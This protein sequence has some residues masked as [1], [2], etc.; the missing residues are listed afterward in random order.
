M[1]LLK[2]R[3]LTVWLG[4]YAMI[5]ACGSSDSTNSETPVEYESNAEALEAMYAQINLGLA[6][7][8]SWQRHWAAATGNFDSASFE[9]IATDSIDT[10]EMPEKNPILSD[11]PLYPYQFHHPEGNGTIDIYSYKVEAQA[12]L[13]Q[14]YLN[15]DSEVIWYRADGMKERLLFMGPSGMFEEG[16]WLNAHEFLVF[17][18]LQEQEGFRPMAWII[19]VDSHRLSQFKMKNVA[20]EYQMESYLDMKLKSVDLASNGS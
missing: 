1:N 15:P 6:Q 8:S 20:K 2:L 14:P 7:K 12:G 17:G 3:Y 9:F 5:T 18:F 13:D 4:L 16:M 19:D 10:M 11:D